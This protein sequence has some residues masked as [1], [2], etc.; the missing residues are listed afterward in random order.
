VKWKRQ[1]EIIS[2]S[3]YALQCWE[4][5]SYAL[6]LDIWRYTRYYSA[7]SMKHL[8]HGRQ[9][10]MRAMMIRAM[11]SWMLAFAKRLGQQILLSRSLEYFRVQALYNR[12][13]FW[14]SYTGENV[15]EQAVEA[16]AKSHLRKRHQGDFLAHWMHYTAWK[17]Q[18]QL[19]GREADRLHKS[20]TQY[21]GVSV[22]FEW[23][24]YIHQ[25]A[26]NLE[27]AKMHWQRQKE[28]S[29]LRTLRLSSRNLGS[30]S[31]RNELVHHALR[32]WKK[33][34]LSLGMR[35]F[36]QHVKQ[37][38]KHD[39]KKIL[40]SLQ[41]VPE[42]LKSLQALR[43]PALQPQQLAAP[44]QQLV[45]PPQS[46][47][48]ADTV[49]CAN[50]TAHAFHFWKRDVDRAVKLRLLQQRDMATEAIDIEREEMQHKMEAVVAQSEA[51]AKKL[52][53][54]K[55]TSSSQLGAEKSWSEGVNEE[56]ERLN[57]RLTNMMSSVK[58]QRSEIES[59]QAENDTYRSKYE[60]MQNEDSAKSMKI[61]DLERQIRRLQQDLQDKTSIDF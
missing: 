31:R 24:D 47:R 52:Q 56:N 41:P 53:D 9:H 3:K 10:L 59:V 35:R 12:F 60:V 21:S 1:D 50:K 30:S 14:Q 29:V 57:A 7:A 25:K 58:Q 22:L 48:K 39:L 54:T 26:L 16:R 15:Y 37:E 20:V 42:L 43:V 61:R 45:A 44:A 18:E 8:M 11:S 28:I 17:K 38:Q 49:S 13:S 19:K 40:L 46:T 55:K 5:R 6:A 4:D 32:R 51:L 23:T 33:R 2:W 36:S 34:Q 27:D